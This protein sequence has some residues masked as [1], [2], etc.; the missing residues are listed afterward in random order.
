MRD[1]KL[2]NCGGSQCGSFQK[3]WLRGTYQFDKRYFRQSWFICPFFLILN[4]LSL[5]VVVVLDEIEFEHLGVKLPEDVTISS[6]RRRN[7]GPPAALVVDT[8]LPWYHI[9]L[10][11]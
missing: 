9:H 5:F 1:G 10:S 11:D 8:S 6:D 7:S 3:T 4:R 2:S